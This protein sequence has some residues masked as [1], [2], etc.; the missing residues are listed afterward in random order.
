LSRGISRLRRRI[1]VRRRLSDDDEI[2][3]GDCGAARHRPWV[4]RNLPGLI[5]IIEVPAAID[6]R[7]RIAVPAPANRSVAEEEGEEELVAE[8]QIDEEVAIGMACC[9][10]NQIRRAL[11]PDPDEVL[12]RGSPQLELPT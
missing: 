4:R 5:P 3:I 2:E 7:G 10:T 8:E 9:P 1:P 12:Y 11:T 6:V